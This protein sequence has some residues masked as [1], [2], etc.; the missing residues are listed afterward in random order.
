MKI[1]VPIRGDVLIHVPKN[2]ITR[3]IDRK[4]AVVAPPIPS[5]FCAPGLRSVA[6]E[7]SAYALHRVLRIARRAAC[8]ANAGM[9]RGAGFTE[10]QRQVTYFIHSDTSH[11]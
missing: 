10:P 5:I 8:E 4:S 1:E 3:G 11:P 6:T 2:A 9:D 7:D